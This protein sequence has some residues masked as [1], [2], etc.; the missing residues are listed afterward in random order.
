MLDFGA[1]SGALLCKDVALQLFWKELEECPTA[2]EASVLVSG[3]AGGS[4]GKPSLTRKSLSYSAFSQFLA[5]VPIER[6]GTED[7]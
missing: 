1:G 2:G 7:R 5:H 6:R 3:G 4:G